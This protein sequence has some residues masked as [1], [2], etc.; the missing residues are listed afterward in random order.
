MLRSKHHPRLTQTVSRGEKRT[1]V[2]HTLTMHSAACCAS[3]HARNNPQAEGFMGLLRIARTPL[4]TVSPEA[5]VMHAVRMMTD[6]SIGALA[7]IKGNRLVGI[8]SE[9]D[10]MLRVVSEK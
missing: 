4:V 2:R 7:V 6:E 9:R 1:A 10:L 3:M 5:T 8:F